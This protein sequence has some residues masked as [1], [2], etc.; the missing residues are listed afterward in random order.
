MRLYTL[1]RI[2]AADVL[3]EIYF[4]VEATTLGSGAELSACVERGNARAQN[5]NLYHRMYDWYEGPR[6]VSVSNGAWRRK[7]YHRNLETGSVSL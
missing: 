5:R 4:K 2:E 7:R 1:M 3:A 6:F